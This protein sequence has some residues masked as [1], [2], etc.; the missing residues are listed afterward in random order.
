M[1]GLVR[2]ERTGKLLTFRGFVRKVWELLPCEEL[3]DIAL[4]PW[5]YKGRKVYAVYCSIPSKIGGRIDGYRCR[6]EWVN[7]RKA[8]QVAKELWDYIHRNG[9]EVII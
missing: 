4:V 3:W 8:K 7:K 2:S 9:L 6:I 5:E 1:K